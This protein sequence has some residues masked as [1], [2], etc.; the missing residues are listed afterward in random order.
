[1]KRVFE[2]QSLRDFDATPIAWTVRDYATGG[3]G[4]GLLSQKDAS[5]IRHGGERQAESSM[6]LRGV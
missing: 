2:R 4:F 5:E 1:M 3:S 6:E